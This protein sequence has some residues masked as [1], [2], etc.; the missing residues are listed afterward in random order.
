MSNWIEAC[1][2]DQL[3]EGLPYP[4][5][6]DDY[7]IVLI[8]QD[9]SVYALADNCTHQDF[10]LSQG[11]VGPDRITCRAHGAQFC[12]KTGKALKAPAF[13]GVKTFTTRID[14]GIVFVDV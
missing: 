8:R 5:T 9:D 11:K 14:D 12:L 10:P 13:A 7:D 1:S 4:V 3:K 2:L 6:L